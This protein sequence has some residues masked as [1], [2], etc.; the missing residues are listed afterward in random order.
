MEAQNISNDEKQVA[1]SKETFNIK[2]QMGEDLI[3]K[4]IKK[5]NLFALQEL[6]G[7]V[8]QKSKDKHNRAVVISVCAEKGGVGKTTTAIT[9]AQLLVNLKF[10]VVVLDTDNISAS[11]KVLQSRITAI[12]EFITDSQDENIPEKDVIEKKRNLDPIVESILIN[13]KSYNASYLEELAASNQYDIII[14]DT[15][16]RK[17]ALDGN[18]DPRKLEAPDVPHIT[19]AYVS[20]A[21]IIPMKT[22]S[23]DMLIATEYY[24]PLIQFF[25]ALKIKKAQKY[26][27]VARIL[28]SM[29]ERG[30][31]GLREL[32]HFKEQT[33]YEFFNFEIR[34]SE[35][36]AN[37]VSY[38]GIDTVFTTNVASGVL[39]SFFRLAQ[40]VFEE[41][42]V[43]LGD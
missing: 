20:N 4:F 42:N 41:I 24:L 36:I 37:K 39:Q 43:G 17:D 31:L 2:K 30:S 25:T 1:Y 19:S 40:E 12:H 38:L 23:L 32:E 28:P 7:N 33:N 15:A 13:V 29:V 26:E 35:K 22:T 18:F 10:R 6:V 5:N 3:P 34:R 8:V 14:V 11:S 9:L 21:I 16:G 27:T